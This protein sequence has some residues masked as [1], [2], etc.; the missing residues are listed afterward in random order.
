MPVPP[1][2]NDI[3]HR[4]VRMTPTCPVRF[5]RPVVAVRQAG[6]PNL[7]E[8]AVLFLVVVAGV[9]TLVR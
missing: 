6:G 5:A 7:V 2:S 9:L 3:A 4:S 1:T 8:Y